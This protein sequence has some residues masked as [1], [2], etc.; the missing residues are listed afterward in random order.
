MDAGAVVNAMDSKGDPLLHTAVREGNAEIARILVDAG[1]DV[2]ARDT[3]R[4][5]VVILADEGNKSQIVQILVDAGAEM[6]FPGDTPDAPGL[7][8][9]TYEWS[10]LFF[11][12]T[13]IS[14]SWD[15]IIGATYYQIYKGTRDRCLALVEAP[16][17]TWDSGD[18]LN[19]YRVKACNNG[20]CS[21]FSNTVSG[22]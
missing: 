13:R 1:A 2:N 3:C 20:R 5:P 11:W 9:R 10:F 12:D 18:H 14:L 4:T 8:W 15:A 19:S 6:G 22:R 16:E 17:T 7:T 21:R